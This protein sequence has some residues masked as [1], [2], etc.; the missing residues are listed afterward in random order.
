MMLGAYR[1]E[2]HSLPHPAVEE[3]GRRTPVV[4]GEKLNYEPRA[5]VRELSPSDS[6]PPKEL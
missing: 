4:V 2:A 6:Q 3:L 5:R 1:V